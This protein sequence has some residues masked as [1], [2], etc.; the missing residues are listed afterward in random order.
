[1]KKKNKTQKTILIIL[2]GCGLSKEKSGNA[3]YHA[4]PFF[5]DSQKL[6]KIGRNTSIITK[7]L[8]AAGR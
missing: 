5:L 2:D 7:K 1:M 3:I 8:F 6:S 4:R